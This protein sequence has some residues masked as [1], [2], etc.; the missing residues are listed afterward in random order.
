V[1]VP[2]YAYTDLGNAELL[3]AQYAD[4][5][6]YVQ[7]RR[8]WHAWLDGRWRLDATGEA[9]RAAK[10]ITRLRLRAS[11]DLDG[12][13]REEA[14]RWALASQA[15]PRVR[16]MLKLASTEPKIVLR[17]EQLD[18]DP[19]LLSVANGVI[20]LRAGC[21]RPHDPADLISL[22]SD[23]VYDPDATC[24]RWMRF[25]EEVF[26]GDMELI[27]YLQRLVGYCL[28]GDTREQIVPV[29]HGSGG[30]GKDTFVRPL[31]RILGDHAQTTP[32]ETFARS[33]R[34]GSVRNDLAR[35]HRARLVVA[36]ESNE[37]RS[38]D[39][40]TLKLVSG[41]GRIAARFLYA[42]HFEYTPRFKVFLITNHRPKVDGDDDAIWRRLREIPFEVSFVGREDRDLDAK[43]EAELPGILA[44]GVRG[45]RTCQAN[46]LGTAAAVERATHDY[47]ADEDVL[48]SFIAERCQPTGHVEPL[49]FRSAYEDYCRDRGEK[50]LTA[51]ALGKRLR[52]RGI[53]KAERQKT[54]VY[55]GISLRP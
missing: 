1:S 29:L 38:L 5:L 41:G 7:E 35:L 14:A 21:L 19:F 37:G 15:E 33:R 10:E 13:E 48:G 31:L 3:A 11:A 27:E 2:R 17:A 45:F 40:A 54:T 26:A 53:G 6:R 34:D 36:S 24:P 12:K 47:R 23:V 28:T 16:A 8:Q 50:P 18:A 9:E 49:A 22:G 20:D 25:L 42:E 4:R 44:W 51:S 55:T 52:Q 46:G 32:F 43:L 30:N 39:E